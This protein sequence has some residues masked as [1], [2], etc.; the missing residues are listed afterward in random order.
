MWGRRKREKPGGSLQPEQ[1]YWATHADPLAKPV[2]G[3]RPAGTPQVMITVNGQPVDVASEDGHKVFT[4][5][6]KEG[7]LT[8]TH[9]VETTKHA[10][11]E[12]GKQVA[13]LLERRGRG[14]LSDPDFA[15][16]VLRVMGS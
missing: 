6:A 4:M 7:Q 10:T 15:A 12:Q 14:E 9:V 3:A 2:G 11:P 13:E 1:S 16:A 8:E 5:L